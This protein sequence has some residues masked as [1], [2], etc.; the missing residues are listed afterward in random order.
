MDLKRSPFRV[1]TLPGGRFG[2]LLAD[3]RLRLQKRFGISLIN[4]RR[5]RSPSERS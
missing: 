2:C 5:R 3:H 1:A 4:A